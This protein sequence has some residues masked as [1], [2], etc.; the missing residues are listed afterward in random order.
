[1]APVEGISKIHPSL[2]ESLPP[3]KHNTGKQTFHE[4]V[5]AVLAQRQLLLASNIA[6]ADTP[7]YKAVDI[8]IDAVLNE[9]KAGREPLRLMAT[10]TGHLAGKP[11]AGTSRSLIKYRIPLQPSLDGNTV[12]MQA[13]QAKFA[14]NALRYQFTL[15]RVG[16]RYKMM[17]E[18]LNDLI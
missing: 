6:N 7:N 16:G 13:E 10:S 9:V 3:R 17:R 12:D 18:L 11:A 5:L 4:K 1:M 15:D 8:D 2:P 14:E